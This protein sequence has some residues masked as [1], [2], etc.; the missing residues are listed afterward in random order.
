MKKFCG[1]CKYWYIMYRCVGITGIILMS[2]WP[3]KTGNKPD[4][5]KVWDDL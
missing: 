5:A 4:Y 1:F 2:C 3:N